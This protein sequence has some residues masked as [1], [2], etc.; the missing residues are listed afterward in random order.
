VAH[1]FLGAVPNLL[2]ENDIS[3]NC[4]TYIEY[5]FADKINYLLVPI[6]L[7][8]FVVTEVAVLI[9]LR[10]LGQYEKVQAGISS[11][12][13]GDFGLFWGILIL[14]VAVHFILLAVK[15]F[16]INMSL[17]KS[18]TQIHERMIEAMLRSPLDFYSKTPLGVL[19]NKFTTDLGV[20]DNSLVVSLIDAIEGPILIIVAFVN[21]IEIDRYF[22]IPAGVLTVLSL[23]FFFYA[24]PAIVACKQLDLKNKGPIF[25]AYNETVSGLILIR[26]LKLREARVQEFAEIINRS[27]KSSIAFDIVSRGFG[28]Y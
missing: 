17:V 25:H 28:F 13:G 5:F 27:I 4:S 10:F 6:A 26:L 3:V 14:L 7:I 12:F 23:L 15:Y 22:A 18:N 16:L 2:H 24:R 8:L 21:M 11:T 9:Y 1:L 20:L 19:T